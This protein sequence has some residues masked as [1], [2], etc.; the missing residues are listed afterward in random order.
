MSLFFHPRIPL[1]HTAPAVPLFLYT[2]D[3]VKEIIDYIDSDPKKRP[4]LHDIIPTERQDYEVEV[5]PR[6]LT[7]EEVINH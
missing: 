2:N 5:L 3:S 6:D 7:D 4:R 1:F